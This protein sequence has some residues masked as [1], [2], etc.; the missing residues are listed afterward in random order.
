VV[1]DSIITSYRPLTFA[2]V[3][4]ALVALATPPAASA[5]TASTRTISF[6][7]RYNESGSRTV[8]G[9]RYEAGSGQRNRVTIDVDERGATIVDAAGIRPGR[10]CR[11]I[12][13]A[14]RREVRCRFR[15]LGGLGSAGDRDEVRVRARLGARRDSVEVRGDFP[16]SPEWGTVSIVTLEGGPGPD[17]LSAGADEGAFIGGGGDDRMVGGPGVDTFVEGRGYGSDAF[18]GGGQPLFSDGDRVAYGRR[19]RG[20]VAD[21]AGDRDD[22][23][24]GERDRIGA[25]VEAILGGRGSDRLTGN[26]EANS[27]YG[28]GG[29]FDVI[30]GGAGT[31]RIRHS[32]RG[33][34]VRSRDGE[35]D[36]LGCGSERTRALA[37]GYDEIYRCAPERSEQAGLIVD[38]GS[39][40]GQFDV[41]DYR[42]GVSGPPIAVRLTVGCPPD[43]GRSRC[44][45][46]ARLLGA[47]GR[48]LGETA[49]DF[50]KRDELD[51][52]VLPVAEQDRQRIE[53]AGHEAATL[54]VD[55]IGVPERRYAITLSAP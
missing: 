6:T 20:I 7:D 32:A 47:D 42:D 51:F 3:V 50:P 17:R 4:A 55:T 29:R 27:L 53:A 41:I 40:R 49:F 28:G 48:T 35:F 23:E 13:E 44:A 36:Q 37:D 52:L 9:L 16:G 1:R 8:V 46:R 34:I 19:T 43:S 39:S 18:S 14:G 54:V 2:A 11:L 45:G 22:G 24:R 25:D 31:D 30:D 33:G 10:G 21:L 38:V 26:G 15:G 5:G 12:P